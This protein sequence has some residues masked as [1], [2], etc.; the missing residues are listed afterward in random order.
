MIFKKLK[1]NI[2]LMYFDTKNILKSNCNYTHQQTLNA[3]WQLFLE[4]SWEG[5]IYSFSKASTTFPKR[6]KVVTSSN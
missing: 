1:K 6:P 5:K 3:K 2:I 4:L